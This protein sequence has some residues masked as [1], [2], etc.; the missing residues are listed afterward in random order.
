MSIDVQV[1]V[2]ASELTSVL[3]SMVTPLERAVMV[4][5]DAKVRALH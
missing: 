1:R 3:L 2:V 5:A 4:T